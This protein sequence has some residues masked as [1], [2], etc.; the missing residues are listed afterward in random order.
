M[1]FSP[2]YIPV[3]VPTTAIRKASSRGTAGMCDQATRAGVS[4]RKAMRSGFD[5]IRGTPS[6]RL[7]YCSSPSRR[8]LMKSSAKN[9]SAAALCAECGAVVAC[10]CDG[11]SH[12]AWY[13][14]RTLRLMRFGS[15]PRCTTHGARSA[16]GARPR[17]AVARAAVRLQ[18]ALRAGHCA[19]MRWS[20]GSAAVEPRPSLRT[21][22][23]AC[24]FIRQAG[25][26]LLGRTP[27]EP[28]TR[29]KPRSGSA[30][31]L[32]SK[33]EPLYL[34]DSKPSAVGTRN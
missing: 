8:S 10:R 21:N 26:R 22:G 16:C 12:P 33:C 15:K 3:P 13:A 11:V 5:V 24:A 7:R 17:R 9:L 28:T 18:L 31:R 25:G 29:A 1:L 4:S 30:G 20:G 34:N 19:C 23:L 32:E 6:R 2:N 14:V 27:K